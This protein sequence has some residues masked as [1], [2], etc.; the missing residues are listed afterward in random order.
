MQIFDLYL[1]DSDKVV[2]IVPKM[3]LI[4]LFLINYIRCYMVEKDR[5]C[6]G[7]STLTDLRKVIEARKLDGYLIPSGSFL[8]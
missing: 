5:A 1:I 6:E 4:Y 7:K 3:K 8:H 2:E